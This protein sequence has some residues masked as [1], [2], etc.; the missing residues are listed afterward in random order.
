MKNNLLI[1]L[2]ELMWGVLII[3]VSLAVLYPV[4]TQ[5]Y[6]YHLGVNIFFIAISLQYFRY[7]LT[8]P[9]IR[10][11]HSK[12]ARYLLFT[13]NLVLIVFL[14]N[15]I[16][17]FLNIK[18][19]FNILDYGLRK[20]PMDLAAEAQLFSFISR[21]IIFFILASIILTF[22]LQIRIVFSYWKKSSDRLFVP[23][24]NA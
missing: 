20:V 14:F 11:F 12:W 21:E 4:S 9:G 19:N 22:V 16:E 2:Q 15:Q 23:Q 24:S 1:L 17:F 13:M 5:I 7:I 8:F 18:D 3:A 10:F 6:F